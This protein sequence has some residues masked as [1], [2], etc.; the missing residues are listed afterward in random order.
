[1]KENEMPLIILESVF[2]PPISDEDF[3][4]LAEQ[5]APCLDERHATWVTSYMALDRRRRVCVFDA[6]DAE[7]VRQAYRMSGVKFERVWAAEQIT[8]DDA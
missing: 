5:V 6:K 7:A 4:K 3:D 2:D 8:A 1:V